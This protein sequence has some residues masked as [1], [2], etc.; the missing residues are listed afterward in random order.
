[1]TVS[2][3]LLGPSSPNPARLRASIPFRLPSSGHVKLALYDMLGREV[4][5]LVDGPMPAG[6]QRVEVDVA[7]LARGS[8]IYTLTVGT[9]VRSGRMIVE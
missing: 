8:Y 2:T 5:R 9:E 6:E 7:G 1:M 4:A 3:L